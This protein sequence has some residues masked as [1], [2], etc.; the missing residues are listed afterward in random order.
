MSAVNLYNV[1]VSVSSI[2]AELQASGIRLEIGDDFA[3]YRQLRNAQTDRPALYPMFDVSCSYVDRSN[4]FWVCGFDEKEELVHTQAIRLLDLTGVTLGQHIRT[5]R[6][7]YITPNS[8]PDPDRTFYSRPQSLKTI[9]GKV[10]YHGDFWLRGGENGHRKQGVTPLLSRV[11]F[12][13]ALKTWVPNFVFGLVPTL[14]AT[15]GIHFRYGYVHCEPGVWHGP[16]NQITDEDCLVWMSTKEIV[17]F[18]NSQPAAR[19]K[20]CS[21]FTESSAL[22]PISISA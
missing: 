20:D 3:V 19:S 5:H 11:V 8:T 13:L 21:I 17:H 6:H 2:I 9:T 4:G 18:L 1:I 15:K 12:E 7:K 14:L 10:C 22:N 16:D